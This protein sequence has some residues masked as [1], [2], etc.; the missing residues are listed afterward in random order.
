MYR[1]PSERS[2]NVEVSM[3]RHQWSVAKK[4]PHALFVLGE[5]RL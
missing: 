3:P 5:C 1:L 2:L 4:A